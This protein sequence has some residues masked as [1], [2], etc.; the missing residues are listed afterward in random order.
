MTHL[1]CTNSNADIY[2]FSIYDIF[3]INDCI[4]N[5]LILKSA[6]ETEEWE[7]NHQLRV[8]LQI[9]HVYHTFINPD[10]SPNIMA[11]IT[12]Y[13]IILLRHRTYKPEI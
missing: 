7:S 10:M 5:G 1:R 3:T 6:K 9:S 12:R 8:E 2:I 11:R 4:Y 13:D